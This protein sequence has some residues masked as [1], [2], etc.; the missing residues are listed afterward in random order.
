MNGAAFASTG[1]GLVCAGVFAGGGNAT[2]GVCTM[3]VGASSKTVSSAI[4]LDLTG[5]LGGSIR[6]AE[7]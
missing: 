6:R 3:T 4:R 2:G 1:T 7:V 5:S